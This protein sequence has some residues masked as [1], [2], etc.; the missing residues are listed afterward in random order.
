MM[1]VHRVQGPKSSHV[2]M[3][4]TMM[5]KWERKLTQQKQ[6]LTQ[7]QRKLTQWER[8]LTQQERNEEGL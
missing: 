8:K 3:Q 6:K 7:Q 4:V 5:A 2:Q 1:A